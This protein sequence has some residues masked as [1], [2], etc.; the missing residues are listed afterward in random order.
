MPGLPKVFRREKCE[1]LI[2]KVTVEMSGHCCKRRAT[3]TAFASVVI[4]AL[5]EAHKERTARANEE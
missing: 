5:Q 4:S 1:P 3:E 2:F